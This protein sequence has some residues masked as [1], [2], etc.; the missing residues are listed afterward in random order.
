[1]AFKYYFLD[2]IRVK[3]PI[4]YVSSSFFFALVMRR[5]PQ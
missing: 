2:I 5:N 3:K 1:M 4:M